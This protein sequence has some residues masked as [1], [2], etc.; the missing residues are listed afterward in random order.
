MEDTRN[1]NMENKNIYVKE[2][3]STK[4]N[5]KKFIYRNLMIL[6]VIVLYVA[7]AE[8]FNITVDELL[9]REVRKT[10]ILEEPVRKDINKMILRIKVLSADGDKINVNLPVPIILACVNSESGKPNINL[11]NKLNGIDFDLIISMIEQ[12][13][14]GTLVEIDSADGDKVYI[15]VE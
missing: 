2:H 12:G 15:S 7:V 9:G 13:V 4:E 8:I 10:E 11:G 5:I 3:I 6:A 1:E 14:V